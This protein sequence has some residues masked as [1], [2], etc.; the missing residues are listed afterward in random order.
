MIGVVVTKDV[1]KPH[2]VIVCLALGR[3]QRGARWTFAAAS[4]R[5]DV[6]FSD[7]W[8]RV[9]FGASGLG[10]RRGLAAWQACMSSLRLGLRW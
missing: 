5:P 2:T 10:G 8:G 4:G 1:M 9:S 6:S 3:A 7:R